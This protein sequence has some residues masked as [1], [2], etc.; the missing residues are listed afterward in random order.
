MHLTRESEYALLALGYLADREGEAPIATAEVAEAR[1]IPAQFLAKIFQKLARAGVLIG[2]RGRGQGYALANPPSRITMREIIL[3]VE[4]AESLDGCLL[5]QGY[6]GDSNPCPLHHKLS[7]TH[8]EVREMMAEVTV[9]DYLE[10]ARHRAVR[11]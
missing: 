1:G 4:G 2:G 10:E 6:C 3:A 5:W 9:A 11:P 8:A 7:Q